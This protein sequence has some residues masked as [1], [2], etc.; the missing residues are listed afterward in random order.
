MT[1][2][3][4][5][6]TARI[7]DHQTLIDSNRFEQMLT[8]DVYWYLAVEISRKVLNGHEDFSEEMAQV[9]IQRWT[10]EELL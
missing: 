3:N 1:T 8:V 4:S 2:S 9:D 6:C 10:S 7:Y 5:F